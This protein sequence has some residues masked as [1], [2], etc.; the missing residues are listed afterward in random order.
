MQ[1]LWWVVPALAALFAFTPL[2]GG[3]AALVR[4]DH[5]GR[6]VGLPAAA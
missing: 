4:G 2:L 3:L 5:T 1:Y 6:W